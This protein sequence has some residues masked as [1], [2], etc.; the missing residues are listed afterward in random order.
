MELQR[1]NILSLLRASDLTIDS[2]ISNNYMDINILTQVH[3]MPKKEKNR[4]R[5]RET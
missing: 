1:I 2:D 3:N 5:M 4:E